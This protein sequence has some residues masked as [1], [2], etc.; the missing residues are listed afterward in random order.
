[1]EITPFESVSLDRALKLVSGGTAMLGAYYF[2]Q[3]HMATL[4]VVKPS[5]GGVSIR[6][7]KGRLFGGSVECGELSP[8]SRDIQL[9]TAS[10]VPLP[11]GIDFES[12]PIEVSL[13]Q[14]F[15]KHVPDPYSTTRT[16]WR[17]HFIAKVATIL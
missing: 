3:K 16:G 4:F 5:S 12:L 11:E 7:A 2:A 17:G 15:P 10:F 1:M 13:H 9:L 6:Y 8:D 14:A